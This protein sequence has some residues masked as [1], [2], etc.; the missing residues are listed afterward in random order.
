[1]GVDLRNN[2]IFFHYEE[3][4]GAIKSKKEVVD[5]QCHSSFLDVSSLEFNK[6]SAE[7]QQNNVSF[8]VRYC[9]FTKAL[10]LNTKKYYIK[11]QDCIYDIKAAV[12]YK[13][14]HKYIDVK[15]TLIE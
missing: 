4:G 6:C 2:I 12:D 10:R 1:M 14:Q 11:F 8:R 7:W 15:A 3:T 9:N 5:Y 13:N